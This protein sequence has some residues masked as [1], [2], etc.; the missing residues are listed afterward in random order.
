MVGGPIIPVSAL[1][2]RDGDTAVGGVVGSSL[3]TFLQLDKLI[4]IIY[5]E[6]PNQVRRHSFLSFFHSNGSIFQKY[7]HLKTP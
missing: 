6:N 7:H 2:N 1:P 5:T 3:T 4:I